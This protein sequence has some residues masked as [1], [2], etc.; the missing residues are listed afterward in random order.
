MVRFEN[1]MVFEQMEFV[2]NAIRYAFR[3]PTSPKA[4]TTPS[5]SLKKERS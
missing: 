5:P 2:L 4:A 1:K 3:N